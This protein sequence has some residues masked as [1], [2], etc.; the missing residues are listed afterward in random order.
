MATPA[1]HQET[2]LSGQSLDSPHTSLPSPPPFDFANPSTWEQWIAVFED[3]RFASGLH[4]AADEVQVRTLLYLMG[5]HEARRVLETFG[6]SL[7]A[8]LSFN[9]V[10]EAF[11]RHFVHPTN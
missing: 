11:T 4:H 10:K 5:S 7:E 6:L 3:F 1:T 2:R 8:L 9:A